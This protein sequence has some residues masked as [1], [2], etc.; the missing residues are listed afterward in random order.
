MS[1]VHSKALEE[2]FDGDFLNIRG[3]FFFPNTSQLT[4][5]SQ[6][7]RR[8]AGVS[9]H[10]RCYPL[11]CP[12]TRHPRTPGEGLGWPWPSGTERNGCPT[13]RRNCV[14]VPRQ[15]PQQCPHVQQPHL[16]T[17]GWRRPGIQDQPRCFPAIPIFP[18][19]SLP[20]AVRCPAPV[21]FENGMFTPR[22]GSH[23]VG[24]NLSFQCEDG[25]TLR[26]S[27]VRQCRPNGMWD[28]ET[29]VCDNGG[30]CPAPQLNGGWGLPGTSESDACPGGL[31]GDRG[32][33]S[34]MPK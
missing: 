19:P 12:L 33:V 5:E 21:S 23:P 31:C 15:Q 14:T 11:S 22:L 3:D 2:G 4:A 16:L 20:P 30:E 18:S 9:R 1:I 8:G 28:G 34:L 24:G 25:L 29:A 10:A 32:L 26:G 13:V 17:A 6:P 7:F 27:P